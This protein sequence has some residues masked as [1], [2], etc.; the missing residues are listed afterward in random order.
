M[1]VAYTI[2]CL[3]TA[4]AGIGSM[5]DPQQFKRWYVTMS[6]PSVTTSFPSVTTSFPS[7]TTSFPSVTT[8]NFGVTTSYKPVKCLLLRPPDDFQCQIVSHLEL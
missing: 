4:Q 3:M 5:T 1:G 2:D 6:C 8:S 7:V